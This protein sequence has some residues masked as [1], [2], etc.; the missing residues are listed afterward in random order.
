MYKITLME[1]NPLKFVLTVTLLRVKNLSPWR[2]KQLF[3]RSFPRAAKDLGDRQMAANYFALMQIIRLR[4][5]Q[6]S[7]GVLALMNSFQK[8]RSNE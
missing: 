6:T 7:T 3:L 1:A 4:L 2:K 8:A 5:L